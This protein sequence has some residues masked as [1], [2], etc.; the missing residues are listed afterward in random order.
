MH[1]ERVQIEEG[2][3]DGLDLRVVPGLNVIIGERGTGK[4]SLIELIRF[5]LDVPGY[6]PESGRRSRDHAIS[7]LGSGQITVSIRHGDQT[8]T[9]TRQVTDQSPK[10]VRSFPAPIIFSQSEVESVGLQPNGRLHLIDEFIPRLADSE[11]EELTA[12]SE[13]SSLMAES[14][15]FRHELEEL[16]KQI[17][18]LPT[19]EQQLLEL[20]PAEKKLSEI[21]SQAAEKKKRADL[22]A[23]EIS[24]MS[25]AAAAVDRF[26]QAVERWHSAVLGATRSAPRIEQWPEAGGDDLLQPTRERIGRAQSHFRAGLDEISTAATEAKAA[27]DRIATRRAPVEEQAR[28]LRKEVEALQSGAGATVRQASQLRERKA[29]LESLRAVIEQRRKALSSLLGRR[30]R[31]MEQLESSRGKISKKREEVA[32]KLNSVL[33]PRIRISVTRAAQHDAF[34][35][36]IADILRG[37]GLRYGELAPALAKSVSPRELLEA[38]ESNDYELVAR[39]AGISKDRSARV[40]A[41]IRESG[42]TELAT[43]AVEDDV[44]LHLLDGQDYKE[45]GEVSTGQRCTV[46]LPLVLSHTERVLIVDQPEDHIDNAFIADTVIKAI[47]ARGEAS[48]TIFSTHNAN[49]PVLGGAHKVIHL[50]SDGLRGFVLAEAPLE[51]P[52]IVESISTVMEGGAEAFK[53]R[54]LFYSRHKRS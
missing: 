20:A 34:S 18:E 7:V 45:I 12:I 53:T 37:S 2:F 29:Q 16:E 46:V 4:T 22:L 23:N 32:A 40:L 11:A 13:A 30:N 39:A 26:L 17:A 3:L 21:S 42:M 43:I 54:A 51:D 28:R 19:I 41:Q 15:T 10:I 35:A 1:I 48:Q 6:T 9:A 27:V 25:V 5:C 47:L 52:R 44:S 50:G 24:S 31:A 8:F 14:N 38:A 49:I 36:A 33:G